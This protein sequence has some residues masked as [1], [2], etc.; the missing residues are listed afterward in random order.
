MLEFSDKE[1]RYFGPKTNRFVE[2][3]LRWLNRRFLLTGKE[4]RV[5]EVA[6]EN[7]HVV[8][9]A[10]RRV[11]NRLLF[12]PNHPTHSDPQ[13]MTE[14]FRQLGAPASFMAAYDVFL[15]SKFTAWCLQRTGCF[16]VDREGS[17]RASLKE[18]IGILKEGER[19]LTIFPEGNVYLMND[20]VTP[21]LDGPAFIGQKAQKELGDESPILAIPVSI[22]VTHLTDAR[23]AVKNLFRQLASEVGA[24]FD[25]AADPV[26]EVKRLGLLALRKVMTSLARSLPENTGEDLAAT[27][28]DTAGEIIAKLEDELE[29]PPKEGDDFIGRIR[30]IR[31]KLHS[32]RIAEDSALADYK[33][34]TLAAEAMLAYRLLTYPGTYL[35]EKPTL[36]R[37]GETVEK[38][39][40]DVRSV[41]VS[42]YAPRR[43]MVRFGE[44]MDLVVESR[45]ET[46]RGLVVSL[47]QG[48]ERAVQSGL[49]SL[50][51]KN[52]CIGAERFCQ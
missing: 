7:A 52:D 16:S 3:G 36:D 5:T 34:R 27:L 17:D 12:L 14:V 25:E 19:G 26:A 51:Q 46:G 49:D 38:V 50:N 29:L 35:E 32:L 15:R 39:L 44:P 4:H 21:F 37:M 10:R 6:V 47:T 42:P 24:S 40:E 30:K 8:G 41:P 11:G 28:Q 13:V 2:G 23:P 31:R 48:F 22:K 18:A 1:Y 43:A 33:A 45:Q 9:E 20:C